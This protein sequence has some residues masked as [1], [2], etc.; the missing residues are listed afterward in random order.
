MRAVKKKA[1]SH[2]STWDAANEEHRQMTVKKSGHEKSLHFKK[3]YFGTWCKT[4]RANLNVGAVDV[5]VGIG[6]RERGSLGAPRIG[7]RAGIRA[8]RENGTKQTRGKGE[9]TGVRR[10]GGKGRGQMDGNRV[11][12]Q[13]E[14][15][16][17]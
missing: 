10:S 11:L 2:E 14:G 4:K 13:R 17:K 1:P 7:T 12:G 3:K 16:T 8:L 5:R 15:Q 6:A 9:Q